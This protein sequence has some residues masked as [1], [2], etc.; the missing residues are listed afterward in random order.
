MPVAARYALD[1]NA[2][3]AFLLREPGHEALIG[4]LAEEGSRS[5]IHALNACEVDYD[6]LR[7][8]HAEAAARVVETLEHIGV[9]VVC[10]LDRDL[11]QLA[12][13]LKA[14]FRRISLADCI[15]VAHAAT[16]ESTL[17]TTD[18]HELDRLA[19]AGPY[20]FWFLR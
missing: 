20:K 3:I 11:W 9:E 6:F 10:R 1:A 18:H 12:G 5:T 8:G 7:R 17:V 13:K 16:S 2:V 4:L 15:A 14:E 19:A